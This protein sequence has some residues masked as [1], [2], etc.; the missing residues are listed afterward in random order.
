MNLFKKLSG[1]SKEIEREKPTIQ[2]PKDEEQVDNQKQVSKSKS[3]RI[4]PRIKVNYLHEIYIDDQSKSFTGNPMPNGMEIPEDQKPIVKPLYEDLNLC[5][6]VDEGNSYKILQNEIFEKNPNLNEDILHQISVNTLIEEIG[7]QIKMN[8]DPAHII[9]VTAGGN[10]E[11]AIILLDNF[12][13]QIHQ[14]IKGNAIISIPARDLLFICKEGNQ[15]A[16]QKLREITKGYF[17]NPETQG[18]LSK[19]LYLKELGNRELKIIE[20]TF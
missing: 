16:T 18:L 13:E 4:L 7:E 8:G 19:A 15:E 2:S 12:W 11:A 1:K 10:F 3:V 9:I 5:F 20:K 17:D 6:A 14:I